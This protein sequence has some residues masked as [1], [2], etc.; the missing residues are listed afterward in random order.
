MAC[1]APGSATPCISPAVTPPPLA[2][3]RDRGGAAGGACA[4]AAT[5]TRDRGSAAAATRRPAAGGAARRDTCTSAVPPPCAGDCG[6]SLGALGDSVSRTSWNAARAGRARAG[7]TPTVTY[8]GPSGVACTGTRARTSTGGRVGPARGLNTSGAFMGTS[9]LRIP[10][11]GN[12][13][14]RENRLPRQG[15]RSGSHTPNGASTISWNPTK[16]QSRHVE[17]SGY[18]E[19]GGAVVSCIAREAGRTGSGTTV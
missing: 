14:R 8:P 6:A 18:G 3:A 12:R 16:V 7:R 5:M 19:G 17:Y 11:S 4:V 15:T 13:W 9:T 10:E 2:T 1:V